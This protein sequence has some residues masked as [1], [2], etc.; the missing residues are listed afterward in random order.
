M[1]RSAILAVTAALTCAVI[2]P[3]QVSAQRASKPA[4]KTP[5]AK[6]APRAAARESASADTAEKQPTI[7]PGTGSIM[8]V[9]VDSLHDGMLPDASV[10][11]R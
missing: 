1:S 2:L 4:P 10:I 3:H 5:P 11:V 9:V 7:Y 8:G 6:S